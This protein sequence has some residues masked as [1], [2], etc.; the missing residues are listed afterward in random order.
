M[1]EPPDPKSGASTNFATRACLSII[2]R[3]L[4]FDK[5]TLPIWLSVSDLCW[6][7]QAGWPVPARKYNLKNKGE[8]AVDK[9]LDLV[10]I[11]EDYNVVATYVEGRK[12]FDRAGEKSPFNESFLREYKIDWR[13]N[14]DDQK[15]DRWK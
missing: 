3:F 10:V 7:R 9:D 14:Q 11:D 12:V 8:L 15:A 5:N 6:F 4:N 2:T 13:M 1:D